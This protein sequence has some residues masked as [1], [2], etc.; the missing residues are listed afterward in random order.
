[1]QLPKTEL[2]VFEAILAR[3]SVRSYTAQ[4]VD[5]PSVHTLLEAAVHAPTAMGREPWAFIVIQD[6]R[7]LRR[8]SDIVKPLFIEELRQADHAIDPFTRPDFNVFHDAGTLI[9]IGSRSTTAFVAADCWLAAENLMLAACAMGLGTCVIGAALSALNK[10]KVKTEL[11]IPVEFS[12][13]APIVVGYPGGEATPV[14]R[15]K[16]VVLMSRRHI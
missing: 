14:A 6:Q 2:N 3:R 11:G 8:L 13:I 4:V 1:M 10:P 16:P 9:V 15:K 5:E 7:L 12:A